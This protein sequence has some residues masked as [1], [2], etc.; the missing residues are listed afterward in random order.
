ML[1]SLASMERLNS[2]I[3]MDVPWRWSLPP[4]Q[5][6]GSLVFALVSP[7]PELNFTVWLLGDINSEKI[8]VLNI[9][10]FY[11]CMGVTASY[12]QQPFPR[13]EGPETSCAQAVSPT[14]R[15]CSRSQRGYAFAWQCESCRVSLIQR[16]FLVVVPKLNKCQLTN[17]ASRYGAIEIS[18]YS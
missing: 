14:L 8:I 5:L 16:L 3:Q 10:A 17:N 6:L 9:Q 18:Q 7:C 2:Y 4:L 15:K 11:G 12:R 1:V 13:A